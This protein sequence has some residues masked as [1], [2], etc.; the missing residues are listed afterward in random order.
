MQDPENGKHLASEPRRRSNG[1][2]WRSLRFFGRSSDPA[3]SQAATNEG[4]SDCDAPPRFESVF[5]TR[6][7]VSL[8]DYQDA[9]DTMELEAL[10]KSLP[11]FDI[12]ELVAH[13]GQGVVYKAVQK[14]TDR[15][16]ALKLL[17]EASIHSKRRQE[18]F[19]REIELV[20]RLRHPNI[21]T[22]YGSGTVLGRP[23]FAMEF[24]DGMP[25]DDYVLLHR[26]PIATTLVLFEKI[27]RAVAS[28]HQRGLIHRDLKPGNILVDLDGEP[29]VLDFGLAKSFV[30]Q[31]LSLSLAGQVVGTLPF[32]SPE[33][34]R[35]ED[36]AVDTRSDI[37][38]LGVI[39]YYLLAGSMPY[40]VDGSPDSVRRNIIETLPRPLDRRRVESGDPSNTTVVD[41]ELSHVVLKA[42]AKEKE[43]RY[44][45]ADAF[46]DDIARYL[47]GDIVEAKAD[48]AMYVIRRTMRRYKVHV[49]VASVFFLLIVGS[50]VA[51]TVL[52]RRADRIAKLARAGLSMGGYLRVGAVNRD[53]GRVDQAR[54]MFEKVIELGNEISTLDETMIHLLCMAHN[55]LASLDR[56]DFAAHPSALA[57]SETTIKIADQWIAGHSSDAETRRL[58]A[59]AYRMQGCIALDA[60][61]YD[62]AA[63]KLSQ[64]VAEF[65]ALAAADSKNQSLRFEAIQMR[66]DLARTFRGRG[67]WEEAF[68][69]NS[70][71]RES[72]IQL[73]KEYPRSMDSL[74]ELALCEN[75]MAACLMTDKSGRSDSEASKLLSTARNRMQEALDSGRAKPLLSDVNRLIGDIELNKKKILERESPAK[76]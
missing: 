35:G 37:Y 14:S 34:A 54:A 58:R 6:S 45:S 71:A 44:Q 75:R 28:V 20:A 32:L 33:Q 7:R 46:A 17:H 27:C 9:P 36:D 47:N 31:D 55:H 10:N 69:M 60:K 30:E 53:E 15:I 51:T 18:R 3:P 40:S 61:D 63:E 43:R 70:V 57:H 76:K 29:H 38:S 67:K 42:L 5:K 62:R 21:V 73:C 65:D 22:V 48:S 24:V 12:L 50:L 4:S 19:E 72:L 2:F 1:R 74:Y 64:S 26:P 52:W 56:L 11:E 49:A 16:V 39:L 8:D 68:Q 13:G 41:D 59:G 23:Y 25:I 66:M